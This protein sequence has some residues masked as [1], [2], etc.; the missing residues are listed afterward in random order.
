MKFTQFLVKK[1]ISRVSSFS[2][3]YHYILSQYDFWRTHTLTVTQQ[4][5]KMG[6]SF[7]IPTTTGFQWGHLKNSPYTYTV[8]GR[9]ATCRLFFNL[10]QNGRSILKLSWKGSYTLPPI[11]SSISDVPLH[12]SFFSLKITNTPDSNNCSTILILSFLIYKFYTTSLFDRHVESYQHVT[13]RRST[14][15]CEPFHIFNF[16]QKLQ[17]P[18]SNIP[19]LIIGLY[20]LSQILV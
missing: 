10:A 18:D 13:Q 2:I 6:S 8:T 16:H 15:L 7:K 12:I 1:F 9:N 17:L 20:K 4:M 3:S 19:E 14:C 11:T 5:N